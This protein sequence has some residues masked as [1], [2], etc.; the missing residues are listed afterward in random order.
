MMR[1][2]RWVPEFEEVMM[3]MCSGDA[4]M[5]ILAQEVDCGEGMWGG[6]RDQRHHWD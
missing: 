5:R 4:W 6:K 3:E 1:L 2:Q